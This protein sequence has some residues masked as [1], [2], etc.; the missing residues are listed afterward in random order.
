MPPS[1]RNL[2]G[3]LLLIAAASGSGCGSGPA[4]QKAKGQIL[5]NG[6]NYRAGDQEQLQVIFY[7]DEPT[8]K[9]TYPADVKPDGTFETLGAEG[10]GIPPGKYRVA[11]ANL[12]RPSFD[13]PAELS[14]PASPI[15]RE[16]LQG[17]ETLE[18]IDIL[19]L[20]R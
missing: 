15:I 12:G 6:K 1:F 9:T 3:V 14:S 19:K 4:L 13:I 18:P 7:P 17:Q 20:P 16:I 5:V 11:V 2:C 10:R 8:P